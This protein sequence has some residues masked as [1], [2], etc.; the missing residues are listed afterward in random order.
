MG[1]HRGIPLVR[2]DANV[3]R[4]SIT[5]RIAIAGLLVALVVSGSPG[6]AHAASRTW[7]ECRQ[8]IGTD[9]KIVDDPNMFFS[10]FQ[11]R[12]ISCA[13]ALKLVSR[14]IRRHRGS[15]RGFRCHK[16]ALDSEHSQI[17]C[18]SGARRFRY[19]AGP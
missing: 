2:A 10:R 16:R 5:V 12:R 11:V 19:R 13:R 9:G 14:H 1:L 7:R 3:S 8:S 4:M 17:T 18:R 15:L 6:P